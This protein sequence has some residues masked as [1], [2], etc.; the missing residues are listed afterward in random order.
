MNQLPIDE[1]PKLIV[2][3][4]VNKKCQFYTRKDNV[5]GF[6]EPTLIF[7]TNNCPK[8][9]NLDCLINDFGKKI[10]TLED[11]GFERK[12]VYSTNGYEGYSLRF[13]KNLFIKL[14]PLIVHKYDVNKL[15]K[16]AKKEY[17][18]LLKKEI[19]RIKKAS[20]N[21]FLKT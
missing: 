15:I 7:N 19:K 14:D 16:I 4:E 21:N 5:L 17:K 2:S 11:A 9:C 1:R 10:K 12:Y 18:K 6:K 8:N 13:D 3:T 20:I